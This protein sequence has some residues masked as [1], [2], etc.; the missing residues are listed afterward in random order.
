M[1][2]DAADD[3][4]RTQYQRLLQR[5]E[6][7]EGE[8]RRLG[9]S[10]WR[11]QE[12]E[13]RR[14][15]RELHDGVGQNLTALKHQLALVAA[16][17]PSAQADQRDKLEAAIALCVATLEDTRELSRL[18]RPPILDDLGL[19][20]ALRSLARSLHAGGGPEIELDFDFGPEAPPTLNDDLR[21]LLFRVVQ[22]ALNNIAKHAQ[23]K[24]ARVQLRRRGNE[25]RLLVEDD[26]R[27]C[28][29]A[30]ALRSGGSGLGGMRER[31]RLYGGRFE[32]QST[33]GVGTRV[34]AAVALDA[35]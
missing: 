20:P 22:E 10:V 23:A 27:G 26:G 15:A 28:D 9:R 18:L 11:V 4:L 1:N 25:L 29:A 17:L 12:D 21:T 35:A 30:L 24:Q 31:L 8:F 5:I 6:A 34:L 2:G 13:R 33:V 3:D 14:L 16:A 19:E 32:I 7:N